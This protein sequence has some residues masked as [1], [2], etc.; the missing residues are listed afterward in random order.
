[1]FEMY[2][3]MDTEN[4]FL[5]GGILKVGQHMEYLQRQSEMSEL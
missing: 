5:P 1:M 4:C 2:M 3:E